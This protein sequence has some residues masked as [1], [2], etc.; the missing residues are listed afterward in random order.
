MK[1][2]PSIASVRGARVSRSMSSTAY[3]ALA[4]A[5]IAAAAH[6]QVQRVD[7]G[8][9]M[10]ANPQVGTGGSNR[11][12]Q[13]YV[14]ING[15]EVI[16]GNVSG[17]RYFH[18]PV[19][20]VSPNE[21]RA[22][23]GTSS[24]NSFSRTSAGGGASNNAL[25]Q[26]YYLPSS[27]TAGGQGGFYAS[28]TG[29]G[30]DSQLVPR[31]VINPATPAS[32][33][34]PD[35][36]V[37]G[38]GFAVERTPVVQPPTP[39][40]PGALL[41]SPLFTMR[42]LETSSGV[43]ASP[44]QNGP[45][46]VR[47]AGSTQNTGTPQEGMRPL[48]QGQTGQE[49]GSPQGGTFG[50]GQNTNGQPGTNNQGQDETGAAI[51]GQR[52]S[53]ITG[54]TQDRTVRNTQPQDTRVRSTYTDLLTELRKSEAEA[55]ARA[56]G[57]EAVAGGQ[58]PGTPRAPGARGREG[59][60]SPGT[61]VLVDNNDR[62]PLTGLPRPGAR[63]RGATTRPGAALSA[64]GL[65]NLPTST[66]TAGTRVRELPSLVSPNRGGQASAFNVLMARAESQLKESKYLD[67]AATYEQALL[68]NPENALALVGKA[69]AE[70]GAG[71][72]QSAAFDLKFV[73]TR[74]PQMVG[75]RYNMATFINAQ[76]QDFLIR[77]LTALAQNSKEMNNTASFLLCYLYYQTG[78]R[79]QL[80]A[81]LTRWGDATGHDN[82]QGVLKRAWLT[83][84]PA[85]RPAERGAGG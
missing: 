16:T 58:Q 51:P 84:E 63:S 48:N 60:R 61:N 59:S 62:D 36:S 31:S 76:R 32:R 81:Q 85:T 75:V 1:T 2:H 15:N 71:A 13:G 34:G 68:A 25:G 33:L 20:T 46:I 27:I 28:P 43:E 18:A 8:R 78:R 74:N 45:G 23:L 50:T 80:N 30:F 57:N 10:D 69:H 6:A 47:T 66:L 54:M 82:W 67:A 4:V 40:T 77:D 73:Y 53:R 37:G 12:I 79:Q 38:S 65:E 19:G 5:V 21:F 49:T 22:P 39:G 70:L 42:T 52:D 56:E 44:G 14:P 9:G 29:S 72:Y 55:R 64:R 7:M 26:S 24:L 11:P 3:G 35:V 17:L 41:T 83:E